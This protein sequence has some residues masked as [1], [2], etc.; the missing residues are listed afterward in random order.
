MSRQA[1]RQQTPSRC[2]IATQLPRRGFPRAAMGPTLAAVPRLQERSMAQRS[3]TP[4]TAGELL[5]RCAPLT[6][7]IARCHAALRARLPEGELAE[8]PVP[9]DYFGGALRLRRLLRTMEQVG[10]RVLDASRG[11]LAFPARRAGRPVWLVGS[12]TCPG[13]LFWFEQDG[14][15]SSRRPVDFGGPWEAE[16]GAPARPSAAAPE[17]RGA[18]DGG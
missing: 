10:A 5:A 3:F 4:E 12:S 11:R 9:P 18:T 14:C 1:D 17:D 13:S 16:P 15:W 7:E 8:R 2:C 6:A